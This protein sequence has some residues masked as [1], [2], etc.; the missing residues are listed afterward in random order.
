MV[1]AP[2][3]MTSVR[4]RYRNGSSER[5][6]S[7]GENSTSSQPSERAYVT[8]STACATTSSGVMRSFASMWMGDVAMKVWMRGNCAWRTAS[9]AAS[10]S[11]LFAR[12]SPQI[13]G[14]WPVS[15]GVQPTSL[16]IW[17]TAS[18]SSG[19]AR[20]KP[21]SM[22]ST[23]RRASWRAMSS[24]CLHVSAAPGDCSPS[25]SVVSKMRR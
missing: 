15:V 3:L 14:I 17:R 16:A 13:T 18:R 10:M 9:H 8:A 20:G 1:V 7:S 19:D 22:M 5:P 11:S 21:A 23:P 2:A 25:R 6:A 12:L 4:M 24:F